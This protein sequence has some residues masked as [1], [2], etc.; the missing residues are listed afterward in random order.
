MVDDRFQLKVRTAS[1]ELDE[2][3]YESLFDAKRSDT[4]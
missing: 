3:V 2:A 1:E 4:F